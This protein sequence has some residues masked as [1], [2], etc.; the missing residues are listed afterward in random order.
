VS[1]Q[2]EAACLGRTARFFLDVFV[3]LA[4]ATCA[5]CPVRVEC[6]QEHLGEEWG[7]WGGLTAAERRRVLSKRRRAA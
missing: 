5:G 4:R 1:W 7:V 6:Q 3:P 2:Q